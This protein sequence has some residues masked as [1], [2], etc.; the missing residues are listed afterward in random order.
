MINLTKR[1]RKK[2]KLKYKN[3]FIFICVI[4]ILIVLPLIIIN[5]KKLLKN[6]SINTKPKI[7][8]KEEIKNN[9]KPEENL[10]RVTYKDGFYY[11]DI[12]E[13]IKKQ[14]TGCSFPRE[15][16]ER[17]TKIDYTDL[18]YIKIKHYDFNDNIQV[19]EIIVN[20]QVAEEI[21]EIFYKLYEEKYPIEKMNLVEKYNCI[22]EN[23]MQDNNSSAFN[24]RILEQDP[25]L[26]WHA[27]GLAIDINPLYNPYILGN[28]VL[29]KTAE[30]YTDRTLNV[31]GLITHDSVIYKIFTDY[32][33]SWGGDFINTKDYQHFFKK[34]ILDDSVR[35]RKD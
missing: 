35:E 5:Y 22:D 11:E 26:S 32:G 4:L 10:N 8:N 1:R 2:R 3:I 14:I 21:V 29:P 19:G 34:G 9:S 18:K 12:G 27:F 20:S 25:K 31:K 33:W 28:E 17:Y 15:F 23:S 13:K 30:K 6:N 7:E 24:Y 16:D